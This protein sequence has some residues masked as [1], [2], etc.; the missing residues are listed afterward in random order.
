MATRK[1]QLNVIG[2]YRFLVEISGLVVGGFSAVSG[3]ESTTDVEERQ[4]GGLNG[5]VHKLPTQTR[6]SNLTLKRGMCDS[7][8]LWDW[9][10]GVA[11]GNG[12]SVSRKDGS[13]I[14]RDRLGKEVC[15]WNFTGAF[16]VKWVG[17]ELNAMSS[18]I[19]VET[20]ELAHNGWKMV[21]KSDD[22]AAQDF[23]SFWNRVE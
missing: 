15:R 7:S 3:L 2:N 20:L 6:F 1:N 21:L 8:D 9:Y 16:P 11:Y 4:E 5:Y 13:I 12:K 17:P 23:G 19:A 14:L 10:Q 22:Q 18:E